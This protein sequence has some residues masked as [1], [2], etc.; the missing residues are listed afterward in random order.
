MLEVCHPDRNRCCSSHWILRRTS[1]RGGGIEERNVAGNKVC[2]STTETLDEV[3]TAIGAPARMKDIYLG[4][5]K[6]EWLRVARRLTRAIYL[7]ITASLAMNVGARTNLS[8]MA[9]L[10]CS[11]A[12]ISC[13]QDRPCWPLEPYTAPIRP[14]NGSSPPLRRSMGAQR[15]PEARSMVSPPLYVARGVVASWKALGDRL[16]PSILD[17]ADAFPVHH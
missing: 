4:P 17:I 10:P 11:E 8:P 7:G 9:P 16:I 5:A 14:L 15:P 6:G 3:P 2:G 1:V 12:R 13:C